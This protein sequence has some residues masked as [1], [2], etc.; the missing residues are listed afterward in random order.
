VATGWAAAARTALAAV[1]NADDR[2]KI[3]QDLT[4]QG[5]G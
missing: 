5:V 2:E 3:E 4:A 1:A